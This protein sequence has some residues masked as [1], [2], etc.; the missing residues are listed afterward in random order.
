M[1]RNMIRVVLLEPEKEAR[2]VEINHS[3]CLDHVK[4]G[5]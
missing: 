4:A 2:V 1:D 5:C 3:L